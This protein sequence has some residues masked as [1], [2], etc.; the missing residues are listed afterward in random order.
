MSDILWLFD[1]GPWPEKQ[2]RPG[3]VGPHSALSL[4]A[5]GAGWPETSEDALA[6]LSEGRCPACGLG[7]DPTWV[8]WIPDQEDFDIAIP[9]LPEKVAHWLGHWCPCC[10][11]GWAIVQHPRGFN[12]P[13]VVAMLPLW[14]SACGTAS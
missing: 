8:M 3:Q 4:V 9:F 6:A 7:L 12:G 5:C 13:R 2:A 11:T 1:R 10:K 14:I